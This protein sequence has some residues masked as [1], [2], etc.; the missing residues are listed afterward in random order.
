MNSV[1]KMTADEWCA[2]EKLPKVLDDDRKIR[3]ELDKY[4]LSVNPLALKDCIIAPN[5]I[6]NSVALYDKKDEKTIIY[7]SE[8]DNGK[9]FVSMSQEK[10]KNG[11][12]HLA[13][14]VCFAEKDEQILIGHE[15]C[16]N[17]L[18]SECFEILLAS[19]SGGDFCYDVVNKT[20]YM[21]NGEIKSRPIT[22]NDKLLI[23]STLDY[24][25]ELA[26]DITAPAVIKNPNRILDMSRYYEIERN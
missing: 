10:F 5:K 15:Y 18:S 3:T 6:N 21:K 23:C 16:K 22:E 13:Y 20:I 11:E 1:F 14:K 4:N 8:K 2:A 19:F 7:N 17:K 12:I 26:S 25:S 9:S 24:A